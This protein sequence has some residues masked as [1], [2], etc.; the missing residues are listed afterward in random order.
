MEL[1]NRL[2]FI[3]VLFSA[4]ESA[5]I[6]VGGAFQKSSN[7]AVIITCMKAIRAIRPIRL[8]K[9]ATSLRRVAWSLVILVRSL[10]MPLVF[11]LFILYTFVIVGMNAFIGQ[12]RRCSDPLLSQQQCVRNGLQW[13]AGENNFDWVGSS[14]LTVMSL[15]SKD[16]WAQILY[17]GL[18]SVGLDTGPIEHSQD[19]YSA[20]YLGVVMCWWVLLSNIFV[21]A[22][23]RAYSEGVIEFRRSQLFDLQ[24]SVVMKSDIGGSKISQRIKSRMLRDGDLYAAEMFQ[25]VRRVDLPIVQDMPA[26]LLRRGFLGFSSSWL[27][28]AVLQ[29]STMASTIIYCFQNRIASSSQRDILVISDAFFLFIFG[30][31]SI[32]FLCGQHPRLFFQSYWNLANCTMVLLAIFDSSLYKLLSGTEYSSLVGWHPQI[33]RSLQL[34]RTFQLAGKSLSVEKIINSIRYSVGELMSLMALTSI[35]AISLATMTVQLF[36]GLCAV[37]DDDENLF[38]ARCLMTEPARLLPPNKTFR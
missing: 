20:F 11:V 30:A 21:A 12:F 14:F 25:K 6:Y 9:K 33:V 4:V 28:E 7:F 29:C 35:L 5:A 15:T 3:I 13:I 1:W 17:G 10:A 16:S 19:A 26:S 32:L 24:S 27:F 2:D 34:V 31:E 22:L 38:G 8:L 23:V 18:S 37:G 36:A